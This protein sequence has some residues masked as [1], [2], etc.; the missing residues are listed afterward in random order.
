MTNV[1]RETS[2]LTFDLSE[3]DTAGKSEVFYFGDRATAFKNNTRYR[4]WLNHIMHCWTVSHI[5]IN[6]DHNIGMFPSKAE[7]VEWMCM[8][9]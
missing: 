4:V 6:G 9:A 3:V 8:R 7:A 5:T 1:N 2:E